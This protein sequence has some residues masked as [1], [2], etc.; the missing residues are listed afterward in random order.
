MCM[1]LLGNL[2]YTHWKSNDSQIAPHVHTPK[3]KSSE[4]AT[5][6]DRVPL[7]DNTTR[8][9]RKPLGKGIQIDIESKSFLKC[10]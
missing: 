9:Q 5:E 6:T 7:E 2:T 3:Q 4:L 8:L 10:Q 1:I